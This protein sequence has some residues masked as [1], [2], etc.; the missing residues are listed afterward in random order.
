MCVY[1]QHAL[2]HAAS[3]A[4]FRVKIGREMAEDLD[5]LRATYAATLATLT[6]NSRPI[7]NTLTMLAEDHRHGAHVIADLILA[8][9]ERVRASF[10]LPQPPTVP[11]SA[12]TYPAPT[13]PLTPRPPHPL[14]P[15]PPPLLP[16][17][18]HPSDQ[19]PADRKLPLLYLVDSIIKN[20]RHPYVA[21]FSVRL[22][23]LYEQTY[24][25][26]DPAV[27][28]SMEK[29]LGTWNGYLDDGLVRTLDAFVRSRRAQPV[30][31]PRPP[32]PPPTAAVV[33]RPLPPPPTQDPHWRAPPF[34]YRDYGAGAP[35]P[36]QQQQQQQRPLQPQVRVCCRRTM[37]LFNKALGGREDRAAHVDGGGGT[38]ALASALSGRRGV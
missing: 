29:L 15:R 25:Q 23:P 13:A 10:G 22:V 1:A 33:Q 14:T 18:H 9:I 2:A 3:S 34:D 38:C 27:Q 31:E 17:A 30:P 4:D 28:R 36:P 21:H 11:L 12:P 37:L 19:A 16:R 7:I 8:Q 24:V 32:L 26:A 35:P 5:G 20:V 6:F